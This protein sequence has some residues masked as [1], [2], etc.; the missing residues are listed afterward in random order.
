MMKRIAVVHTMISQNLCSTKKSSFQSAKKNHFYS[1]LINSSQSSPSSHHNP[2]RPPPL[3]KKRQHPLHRPLPHPSLHHL[4]PRITRRPTPTP[5]KYQR[6]GFS[7][8]VRL[9]GMQLPVYKLRIRSAGASPVA[10]YRWWGWEVFFDVFG[11]FYV[12]VRCC[13]LI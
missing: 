12:V 1:S 2:T 10:V 13:G 6:P 7:L 5:R 9:I 11:I 3:R 8:H 4:P